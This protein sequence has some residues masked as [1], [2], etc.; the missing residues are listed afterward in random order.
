MPGRGLLAAAPD[1]NRD[2]R[3][4]ATALFE[5]MQKAMAAAGS[6]LKIAA[7][8]RADPSRRPPAPAQRGR[9]E[10]DPQAGRPLGAAEGR[11][12]GRPRGLHRRRRSWP[13]KEIEPRILYGLLLIKA[14]DHEAAIKHLEELKSRQTG[15]GVPLAGHRLAA[16]PEA[17]LYDGDERPAGIAY[18]DSQARQGGATI[19]RK[20]SSS[21]PGSASLREFAALAEEEK[22][23]PAAD[24]LASLDAAVADHGGEADRFYQEGRDHSHQIAEDYDQKLAAAPDGFESSGFKVERRRLVHYADFPLKQYVQD[25]LAGLDRD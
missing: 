18:E 3:V 25:V 6:E 21:S 22:Y 2:G 13:E 24:L 11:S 14:K 15:P 10:G 17:E 12:E 9:Q 1:A 20:S 23:R 19:P 16:I 8:A 7:D 4:E 5:F